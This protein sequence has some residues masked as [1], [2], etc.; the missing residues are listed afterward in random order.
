MDQ[1][2][3]LLISNLA[4]HARPARDRLA[5]TLVAA[6]NLT[7]LS[8]LKL[9]AVEAGESKVDL[10]LDELTS[11]ALFL[12]LTARGEPRVFKLLGLDRPTSPG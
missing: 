7:G 9:I 8:V 10:T 1:A 11:L 4:K 2:R 6:S 12:G 5:M 3:H